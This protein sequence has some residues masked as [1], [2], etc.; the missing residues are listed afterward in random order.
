MYFP[1]PAVESQYLSKPHNYLAHLLG[2]ESAGSVLSRLKALG[3]ANSLSAYASE[4]YCDFALM[5][6]HVELTDSGLLHYEEVLDVLFAY[7][8]MIVSHGP[9]AWIAQEV[10]DLSQLN[11]RFINKSDPDSYVTKLA[12]AMQ[13]YAAEHIVSGDEVLHQVDLDAVG[14]LLTRLTPENCFVVLRSKTFDDASFE[15][16]KWYGV[17]YS[18]E[19]FTSAQR[20]RWAAA[21]RDHQTNPLLHLPEPNPF[22]PK[23]FSLRSEASAAATSASPSL[24]YVREE[25]RTEAA[26]DAATGTGWFPQTGRGSLLWHLLDVTWKVPK[27]TIRL[28]IESHLAFATPL[29]QTLADAFVAALWEVLSEYSYYADCAGLQMKIEASKGGLDMKFSGY[30][31]KAALLVHRAVDEVARLGDG[32]G[33]LVDAFARL[34]EKQLR[35]YLNDNLY[36]QPYHKCIYGTA[37]CLEE[38][39][40]SAADKHNAFA[41]VV[42]QDVLFFGRSFL[43]QART[44]LF[45]HGNYS[46]AEA[47]TL[48]DSVLA[49]LQAAPLPSAQACVRRTVHLAPGS[50][51][52]YRQHASFFNADE[53]NSAIENSYL[54]GFEAGCSDDASALLLEALLALTVHLLSEPAFDQLRTKEQLGYIASVSRCKVGQ[55]LGARVIVQSNSRDPAYLDT[56]VEAFLQAYT[57]TLVE[58]SKE[59]FAANVQAVVEDLLEKPKNLNQVHLLIVR[60]R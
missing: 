54:V 1:L 48:Y 55:Q 8:G 18:V 16:E 6:V 29:G 3:Y 42:L 36:A 4:S 60:T 40:W 35:G 32:T 53:A 19:A 33:A 51:H 22:L 20:L 59:E 26:L 11:F 56:R 49:K 21:M 15:T 45:V 46:A 17:R 25:R 50:C 23:D 38:P 10:K 37:E 44:E 41:P 27:V 13:V 12:Y 28:R 9:L 31:D 5:S 58:L 14:A 43:R 39:R 47:R 24:I 52:V 2:H 7:V 30:Q 57:E 34:K